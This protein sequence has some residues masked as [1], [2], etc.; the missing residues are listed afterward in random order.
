MLIELLFRNPF[1]FVILA[2][3]LIYAITLHEVAHAYSAYL[4]G[5]KSQRWSGRMTLNPFRHL[6]PIGTIMLFLFG[7]G[8]AKPVL[9]NFYMLRSN[10]FGFVFVSASGIITNIL[11]AF[12]SLL[13]LKIFLPQP[14]S[15]FHLLLSYFAKINLILASFNLIPIPPLDGSKIVQGLSKGKIRYSLWRLEPYGFYI[16]IVLLILGILDPLVNFLRWV[17]LSL[18]EF[19]LS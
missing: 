4:M 8:W 7:F 9:I 15:I 6:D 12:L 2:L 14:G 16:I 10:R 13:F 11:L 19:L 18:I 3:P 17:L 1:A 5:D